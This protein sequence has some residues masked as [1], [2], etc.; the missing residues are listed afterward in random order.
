[1]KAYE[2][3]GGRIERA[4]FPEARHGFAQQAS[5]DTDRCVALVRDF[6]ARQLGRS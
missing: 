1:M 6:I 5:P 2:G 4:H 3:A